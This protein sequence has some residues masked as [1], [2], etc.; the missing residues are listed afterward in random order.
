MHANGRSANGRNIPALIIY[1]VDQNGSAEVKGKKPL[2]Y[3]REEK[4]GKTIDDSAG[5]FDIHLGL[6]AT[7][8][9]R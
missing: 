1:T 4:P 7:T 2:I 9:Y 6:D 8:D 3:E 5:E